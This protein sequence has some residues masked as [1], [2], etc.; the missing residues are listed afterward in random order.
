M[1][2]GKAA[3]CI[4]Q[5]TKA[6]SD[7]SYPGA[8]MLGAQRADRDAVVAAE[9]GLADGG[10]ACTQ[11]T[12]RC[13]TQSSVCSSQVICQRCMLLPKTLQNKCSV[14]C[15]TICALYR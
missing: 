6:T 13:D 2:E 15:C 1:R 4:Q 9:D 3:A 10:L 14:I 7:T 8:R 5:A 11:K 12:Q